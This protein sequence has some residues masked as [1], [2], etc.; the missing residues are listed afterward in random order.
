MLLQN[1]QKFLNGKTMH[2][3]DQLSQLNTTKAVLAVILLNAV[4]HQK[5]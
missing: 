2:K 5:R 4:P 3:L 1:T